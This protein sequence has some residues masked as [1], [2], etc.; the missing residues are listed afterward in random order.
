MRPAAELQTRGTLWTALVEQAQLRRADVLDRLE[1]LDGALA[2]RPAPEAVKASPE[3][4]EIASVVGREAEL[5]HWRVP[6]WREHLLAEEPARLL[7]H[8]LR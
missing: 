8:Q 6:L 1:A 4:L 7:A 5:Y 3:R 2:K